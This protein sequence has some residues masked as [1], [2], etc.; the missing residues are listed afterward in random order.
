MAK[1][2][3]P[4]EPRPSN[5]EIRLR[6]LQHLYE[7]HRESATRKRYRWM[8]LRMKVRTELGFAPAETTRNL[9]YLIQN[10]FIAK[11]TEPYT[12]A[13]GIRLAKEREFYRI[14]SKAMEFFEGESMF[15]A[16]PSLQGLVVAGDHNIVQ[17]GVNVFAHPKYRDLQTALESLLHGVILT[18]DL[19]S[20]RKFQAIADI[21]AIQAQ[22]LKPEPEGVFLNKLKEG[23]SWLA[24]FAG[25]SNFLMNVVRHWPF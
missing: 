24:K 9:D 16:G 17:V 8:D 21:K 5:E 23:I 6:I 25:L 14:S 15:S 18:E 13:K 19:P 4:K 20:D 1:K 11:D 12:G 22:L 3:K 10:E 7:E 2:K